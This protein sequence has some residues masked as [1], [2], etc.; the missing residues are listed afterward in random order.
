[1]TSPALPPA[2]DLLNETEV[3][4]WLQKN[5]FKHP[6]LNLFMY[7]IGA[8]SVAFVGYTT[9]LVFC[10]HGNPQKTA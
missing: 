3:L 8:V 7:A 1:M 9:F 6:E 10:F 5:R 4:D 2:G